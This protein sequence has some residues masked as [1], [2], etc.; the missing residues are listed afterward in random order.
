MIRRYT[1]LLLI[2]WL[3]GCARSTPAPLSLA[4]G[5]ALRAPATVAAGDPL[6]IMVERADAPEGMPVTL[7]AQTSY[8]PLVVTAPFHAGMAEF[9]LP[10]SATHAAGMVTLTAH[11]DAAIG[12]TELVITPGPP[13]DPITPLVGPRTIIADGTHWGTLSA[14]PFDAFGNPVAEGTP[15]QFRLLRPDGSLE[16]INTR[17]TNL[18]AWQRINSS[19]HAGRTVVVVTAG[20]AHGPEA[21]L[22]ETPGWP[23]AFRLSADPPGLPADGSRLLTLRT[24]PIKDRYGNALLDG[25]LVTFVVDTPGALPRFIPAITIGGIAEAQLQA[26]TEPTPLTVRATLYGII[27]EPLTLN[28]APGPAVGV[29]RIRTSLDEPAGM[30]WIEAGPLVGQLGQLVPEGTTVYF[31]LVGPDQ[32]EHAFTAPAANGRAQLELRLEDLA[33]GAYLVEVRVG[34][35]SGRARMLIP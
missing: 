13:I 34:A 2:A 6:R 32:H 25:T 33:R 27:S 26:P 8:G 31:T 28:F 17:V 14:I 5:L 10:A 35:G 1:I 19:T 11:A 15:V 9:R 20:E 22:N 23:V 3:A 29:I 7:V 24:S 21:S 30:V 4:G 12:R 16:M 18:L